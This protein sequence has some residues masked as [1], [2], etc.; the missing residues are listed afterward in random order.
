LKF[1][2]TT[3]IYIQ[4]IQQIKRDIIIGS[5]SPGEKL[6]STRELALKYDINPNTAQRIY[7]EMERE[8]MCFTKRGLGTFVTEDKNKINTFREEMAHS[9]IQDFIKGMIDLG[10]SYDELIQII[11]KNKERG[12]LLC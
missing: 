6:P 10:F 2:T 11:E 4:V 12:D 7:K 5:I 8:E 9:L 3:P 1:D